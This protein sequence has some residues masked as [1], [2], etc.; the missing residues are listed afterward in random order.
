M[1]GT[2]LATGVEPW[3]QQVGPGHLDTGQAQ[4]LGLPGPLLVKKI[5]PFA[6]SSVSEV[7][8]P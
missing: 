6:I 8:L 2:L 7:F 5:Q 3:T 4:R 1:P